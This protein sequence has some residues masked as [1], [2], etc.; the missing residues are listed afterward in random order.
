M[1][2]KLKRS[3]SETKKEVS[4]YRY[5]CGN[6]RMGIIIEQLEIFILEAENVLH[7][8]VYYHGRK[9]A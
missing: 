8:R 4:L 5:F 9:R 3:A 2:Q 7:L 6:V 1:D